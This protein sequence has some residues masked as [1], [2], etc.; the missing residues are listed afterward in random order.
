MSAV[1]RSRFPFL[2]HSSKKHT[3]RRVCNKYVNCERDDPPKLRK[4]L[5]EKRQHLC[6]LISKIDPEHNIYEGPLRDHD[7]LEELLS[8]YIPFDRLLRVANQITAKTGIDTHSAESE[9]LCEVWSTLM[10][11][12]SLHECGEA[13]Y[14]FKTN[15]RVGVIN[16]QSERFRKA[17][18]SY[19][20]SWSNIFSLEERYVLVYSD[21]WNRR[22]G[23]QPNEIETDGF[24]PDCEERYK[25]KCDCIII[26]YSSHDRK[27]QIWRADGVNVP[28]PHCVHY[29][30][31]YNLGSVECG[32]MD[33]IE[34]IYLAS[35]TSNLNALNA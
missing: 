22:L 9:D 16:I 8:D 17:C 32:C 13:L 5:L 12:I 10:K 6:Y 33:Y 15:L 2:F 1:L 31:D 7:C 21:M 3:Y 11:I 20:A 34:K 23:H 18:E 25:R 4:V 27:L 19:F 14:D 26:I 29:C 24:I 35:I 30:K 28:C